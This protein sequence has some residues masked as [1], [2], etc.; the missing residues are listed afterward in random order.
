MLLAG[1]VLAGSGFSNE[2]AAFDAA[3]RKAPPQGRPV[4]FVGSS[5]FRLW[6]NLPSIFPNHP[7]INRGFGGSQMGDVLDNYDRLVKRYQPRAIFVYEG[8]NDLAAGQTPEAIAARFETFV[9]QVR[10]DFPDSQVFLLAVKPSPLRAALLERQKDLN[11]R[12]ETVASRRPGVVLL[13]TFGP[14]LGP[15][16]APEPS[17]FRPDRLHLSIAGYQR[18]STI[19]GPALKSIESR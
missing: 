7:I 18:W 5:S 11:Q 10:G 19:V 6:P 2:F 12:L 16:G 8:D 17:F 14:L 13:D 15:D 3:D 4:L 1:A 9:N